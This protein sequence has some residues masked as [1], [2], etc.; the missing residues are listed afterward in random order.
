MKLI[1]LTQGKF[2][3]VDDENYDWLIAIGKWHY[4]KSGYAARHSP[5]IGGG[6][7][8]IWMHRLIAKTP[9][10]METDHIDGNRL[11]NQ[12]ENLRH[13]T[14]SQNQHNRNTQANNT[15]GYKGVTWNRRD[16]EW[17]ARIRLNWKSISLGYFS[18]AEEAARVY[19]TAARDLHGEFANIN[20]RSNNDDGSKCCNV[21]DTLSNME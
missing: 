4:T 19:D 11:N 18:T 13:C 15:S 16:K 2:T 5:R 10:D 12:R 8:T 7:H 17:R 1:P 20:F 21:D 14:L 9:V 6:Q 3:M